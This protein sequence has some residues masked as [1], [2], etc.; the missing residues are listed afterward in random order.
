MVLP[1]N[2]DGMSDAA[3]LRWLQKEGEYSLEG[4]RYVLDVV[5]G[6][7]NAEDLD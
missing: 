1:E 5:R 4:A 6:K 2:P 3:L 7:V